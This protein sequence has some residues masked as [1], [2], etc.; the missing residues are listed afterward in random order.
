MYQSLQHIEAWLG[1]IGSHRLTGLATIM[2]CAAI[3]LWFGISPPPPGY[4][5]ACLAGG[6]VVMTFQKLSPAGKC[7]WLIFGLVMVVSEIRAIGIDRDKQD[8]QHKL[9]MADQEK[10]H[11]RLRT[12]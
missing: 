5:V 6:A 2:A 9:E 11:T 4:A 3:C 7:L 12:H 1:R 10:T 8:H